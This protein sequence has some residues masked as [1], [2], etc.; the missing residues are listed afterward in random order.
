MCPALELEL[1]CGFRA[2][3]TQPSVGLTGG[4]VLARSGE[5]EVRVDL[6]ILKRSKDY[7]HVVE[8]SIARR[9]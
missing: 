8:A 4:S 3:W 9:E 1:L 2:L 6:R 7:L 5:L